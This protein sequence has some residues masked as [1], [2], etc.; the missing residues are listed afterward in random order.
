MSKRDFEQYLDMDRLAPG[1]YLVEIYLRYNHEKS[2]RRTVEF[3]YWHN[4]WW[5]W[6]SDWWEGEEHVEISAI[7]N[8]DDLGPGLQE[9]VWRYL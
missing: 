9:E 3:L 8:V 4:G 1:R 6:E 7:A 2:L 5:V